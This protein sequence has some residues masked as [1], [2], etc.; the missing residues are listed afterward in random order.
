MNSVGQLFAV[1]VLNAETSQMIHTELSRLSFPAYYPSTTKERYEPSTAIRQYSVGRLHILGLS[2]DGTVWEWVDI[3]LPARY[4]RSAHVDMVRSVVSSTI[5]RV[6]RVTVGMSEHYPMMYILTVQ[7]CAGSSIYVNGSGVSYWGHL[8][9]HGQPSGES[10]GLLIDSVNIPGT[11]YKR[12]LRKRGP[13]FLLNTYMGEVI[14]HIVMAQHIVFIT[15]LNK[16]FAFPAHWPNL[17]PRRTPVELTTFSPGPNDG[18]V[19]DIQGS[20]QSFAVFTTSGSVFIGNQ[21]HLVAFCKSTAAPSSNMEDALPTPIIIPSLQ[22]SSVMSVA[23]GDYHFHALRADGTIS[24]YGTEPQG[25]GALGLGPPRLA[26]LRG[27]QYVPMD[28]VL[29]LPSWSQGRRTVW[30]EPE[31]RE[32]LED[33]ER[34]SE[35]EEIGTRGY[36]VRLGLGGAAEVCG[37]W[38]EQEGRDWSRGPGRD[39][40]ATE[41]G[42]SD[43][44]GA[45]FALKISAAGWHSGALVLVDREKA[46]IV[47]KK[48]LVKNAAPSVPTDKSRNVQGSEEEQ[49]A[50]LEEQLV[51]LVSR[52]GSWVSGHVYGMGRSFLG[53]TARDAATTIGRAGDQASGRLLPG[54]QTYVWHDQAFPRLRLPNGEEMPGGIPLTPWRGG[55]PVFDG[56]N[57]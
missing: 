24:S 4:I 14:N 34:K 31:K 44:I 18:K 7:G 47:R 15:D 1:G 27:V 32:W 49:V 20:F 36:M 30:I 40:N 38:F 48:Y 16:V 5:G 29:E 13:S 25:C 43:K 53:L 3:N 42:P 54:H 22:R 55:E 28:G 19:H 2:D 10:D 52:L 21:D 51:T 46:D 17:D 41:D 11:A 35:N 26:T 9:V 45:Y 50:A 57:R 8:A 37:E 23:F 12:N 6:T 56:E 33:I 39:D